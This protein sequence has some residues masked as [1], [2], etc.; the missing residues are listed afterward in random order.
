MENVFVK[1]RL[2]NDTSAGDVLA[3]GSIPTVHI[4]RGYDAPDDAG[5]TRPNI[6]GEVSPQVAG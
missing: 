3:D 6:W 4:C 1:L 5:Y 2:D